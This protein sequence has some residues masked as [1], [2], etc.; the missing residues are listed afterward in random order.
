MKSFFKTSKLNGGVNLS[1]V[2]PPVPPTVPGPPVVPKGPDGKP[3]K[4]PDGKVVTPTG[5]DGKPE[6]EKDPEG[7]PT[8]PDS[9]KSNELGCQTRV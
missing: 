2:L 1:V 5:P 4:G 7:K 8:P 6:G 3:E 9:G